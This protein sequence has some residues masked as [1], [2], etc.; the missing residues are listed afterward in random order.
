M[1]VG[2][3]ADVLVVIAIITVF[4]FLYV[5]RRLQDFASSTSELSDGEPQETQESPDTCKPL[6]KDNAR[7][8]QLD[9]WLDF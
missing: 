5:R 1:I 6:G 7:V 3:T 4:M 9:F 2:V 8:A